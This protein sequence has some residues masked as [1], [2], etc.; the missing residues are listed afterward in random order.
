MMYE[1]TFIS[2]SAP[3]AL[4]PALYVVDDETCTVLA[5]DDPKRPARA[6]QVSKFSEMPVTLPT[7]AGPPKRPRALNALPFPNGP[8]SVWEAREIRSQ[9]DRLVI[10]NGHCLVAV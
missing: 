10:L 9:E 2:E 3:L 4:N 1:A 6:L 8:G 7:A 5:P